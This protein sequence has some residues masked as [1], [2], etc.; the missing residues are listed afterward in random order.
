VNG[1]GFNDVFYSKFYNRMSL[2]AFAEHVV[3]LK[4]LTVTGGIMAFRSSD[5][6]GFRVYPGIDVAYRLNNRFRLYSSANKT[7]RMPTFTD[8]FYKSPV[9][10]GNPEL[11]PEEALSFEG[12]IRF[13]NS[14]LKGYAGV[15]RSG[16]EVVAPVVGGVA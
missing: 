9:Q 7:L 10:Q 15:F 6:A 12:G 4:L 3:S 14:L 5:L 8:M 16:I 1:A 11:N 13:N 2:S